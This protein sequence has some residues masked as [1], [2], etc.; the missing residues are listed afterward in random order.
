MSVKSRFLKYVTYDTQ[1]DENGTTTPSTL[2]QLDLGR[3]LVSELH[4]MGVSNA[5]LDEFGYVYA[6]VEKNTES[7]TSIGLIAHLDTATELS[8]KNVLPQ[9]H[10]F[11]GKTIKISDD[12][13][14]SP[15]EFPKLARAKGHEII[16]AS[17]NTLLGAD[18]K[19]G[20][21]IIMETLD[22]IIK[23]NLAHPTIYVAFTPDEEI[24]EGTSHFNYDFFKVDFAYT[25]DGGDPNIINYENFNASSA[26]VTIKG[27]AIHPG[28]AKN[29]MVNSQLVAMEFNSMLNPCKT[30]EHTENYE[31]FH[32]LTNMIGTVEESTLHYIIRDHDIDLLHEEENAF[33]NVKDYLNKKYHDELVSVT[34]KESYLNMKELVLKKP[35]VLDYPAKALIKENCNPE[36]EPI[37]GGTDGARLSYNGVITP[38]LGTGSYNHH[39]AREYADVYEMELMVRVV[40]NILEQLK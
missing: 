39:G 3:A 13:F 7:T 1:S 37:R 14:L 4:E 36:F 23:E 24:G 27:K 38:N 33:L 18:D 26:K 32:H 5:Y 28:S 15:I 29:K 8:G 21:A 11:E 10:L 2:K 40:L 22:R 31:G 17:G 12:V 16:T 25:L 35:H 20:I 9:I 34:I 30:P 19:A 6:V